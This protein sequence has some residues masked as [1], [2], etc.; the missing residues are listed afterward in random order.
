MKEKGS[1]VFLNPK[2]KR[3]ASWSA[4]AQRVLEHIEEYTVPQ[5]GDA[6]QDQVTNYSTEERVKQCQKYL[7]R[8]GRNAREGQQELDF[9]K[10]AHYTQL[11]LEK[12]EETKLKVAVGCPFKHQTFGQDYNFSIKCLACTIGVEC[13]I[14]NRKIQIAFYE[15]EG[16]IKCQE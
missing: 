4:F 10:I 15:K 8:F 2:S 11:S 5:Y 3:G 16:V 13:M 9:I 12:Y 6:G 7:D 14:E 1:H